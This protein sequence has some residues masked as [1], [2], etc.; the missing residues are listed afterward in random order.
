MPT[1]TTLAPDDYHVF[2]KRPAEWWDENVAAPKSRK[3]CD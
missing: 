2:A 3:R 1:D